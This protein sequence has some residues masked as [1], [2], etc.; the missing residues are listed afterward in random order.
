MRDE[1]IRSVNGVH[2]YCDFF[3]RV[4]FTLKLYEGNTTSSSFSKTECAIESRVDLA[5]IRLQSGRLQIA[6]LRDRDGI[7]EDVHRNLSHI[8]LRIKNSKCLLRHV[9]KLPTFGMQ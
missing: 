5:C 2:D 7:S 4:E 6:C 3:R 1:H 9:F 8:V